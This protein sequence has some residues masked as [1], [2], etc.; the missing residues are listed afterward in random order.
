M[1][2]IFLRHSEYEQPKGV[3]SALLPHP[4]TK[5]G[6]E[7]AE[8]GAE[9]LVK[10]FKS[11]GMSPKRIVSSSLLRAYQTSLIF[12]KTIE[13]ELNISLE[14]I[15]TDNL[16]ERKLGAMANLTVKEIE[17]VIA[18]DPRLENPPKGWKSSRDYKLPFI[19]AESLKDAGKRVFETI[20]EECKNGLTIFVGHGASFR[21][22]A[23]EFKF[24]KE[25]DLPKL[26]MHNSEPL[27]FENS[28]GKWELVFGDWKIRDKKD[29][30]D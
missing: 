6:I 23:I 21:N 24:L 3:P 18:K 4:I 16:T 17:S 27:G 19:G 15:E 12:K 7:Q 28:N 13:K 9:K 26:S 22:A 14:L 10:F 2:F 5:E 11:K 30:I 8:N 29:K 1:H 20:N 25:E